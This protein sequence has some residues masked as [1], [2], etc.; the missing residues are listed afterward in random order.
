MINKLP[1]SLTLW[2]LLLALILLSPLLWY[3]VWALLR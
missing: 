3:V 1:S 2:V